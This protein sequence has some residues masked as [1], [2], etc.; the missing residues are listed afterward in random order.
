VIELRWL[1]TRQDRY[2]SYGRGGDEYVPI[3]GI[4]S[5]ELEYRQR[6]ITTGEWS[7]W[8]VVPEV[9]GT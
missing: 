4:I 8:T 1:I 9:E 2:G 5:R 7:E 6:D 3:G